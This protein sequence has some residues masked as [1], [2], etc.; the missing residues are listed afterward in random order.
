MS[1]TKLTGKPGVMIEPP[2]GR[3]GKSYHASPFRDE[4]RQHG[5][6]LFVIRRAAPVRPVLFEKREHTAAVDLVPD[7]ELVFVGQYDRLAPGGYLQQ[8]TDRPF[9]PRPKRLG[10]PAVYVERQFP[11]A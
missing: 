10:A 7:A 9:D 1:L 4:P 11:S 2:E 6:R 5:D 3:P 8:L